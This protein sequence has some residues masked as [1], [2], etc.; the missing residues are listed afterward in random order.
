MAKFNIG[1]IVV[2][3]SYGED[4]YFTITG[5]REGKSQKL[6]YV[7][8]GVFYRIEADAYEEDLLKED[9]RNVELNLKMEF[10]RAKKNASRK[11][12]L[13]RILGIYRLRK[14]P[15]T[16][17]HI[18]SS[19]RFLN[20]CTKLYREA[21]IK[22][23]G[24]VVAER[25]QPSVVRQI[26]SRIRP[27]I[28][29]VTGHDGIKKGKSNLSNIENYRNSKYYV[30]SVKEARRYQ[31]DPDKLCIFAGACQSYFEAIM[32]AGANFASSPGRINI[33]ALD[34]AILSEKVALTD[35]RYYVTPEE[36]SSIIISG[37]AGVGGINTKGRLITV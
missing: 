16:I 25:N 28:L 18:D 23:K 9:V 3:K 36:V 17:L 30:Q 8:K 37:S 1:D 4:I 29:V 14:I 34:P 11:F 20:M 19:S 24:Y 22:S 31:K 35:R 26:L 7:L 13:N 27:D 5:I 32:D 12:Y 33:N 15:G 2:R 6:E 10:M 21:G